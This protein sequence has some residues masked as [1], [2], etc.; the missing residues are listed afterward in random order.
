MHDH[1]QTVEN[2]ENEDPNHRSLGDLKSS[3]SSNRE[4]QMQWLTADAKNV[5]N[6][7]LRR[8]R[9]TG[10]EGTKVRPRKS[11]SSSGPLSATFSSQFLN[12]L[13]G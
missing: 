9:K 13:L 4:I 2:L 3:Y 7:E 12:F 11:I 6:S 8:S 10:T 5:W 1:L